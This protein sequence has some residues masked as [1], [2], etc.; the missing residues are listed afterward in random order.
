MKRITSFMFEL[1]RLFRKVFMKRSAAE[2]RSDADSNDNSTNQLIIVLHLF[3]CVLKMQA[4][5]VGVM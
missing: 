5:E 2:A 3:V 4:I 1:K